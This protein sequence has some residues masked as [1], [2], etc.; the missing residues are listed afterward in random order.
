MVYDCINYDTILVDV[1][2]NAVANAGNDIDT[3][4]NIGYLTTSIKRN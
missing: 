1:F 3:C 4:A 2:A